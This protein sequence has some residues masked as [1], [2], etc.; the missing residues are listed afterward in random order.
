MTAQVTAEPAIH[1]Q[2]LEKAYK[3]LKVL[4]GVDFEVAASRTRWSGGSV[5]ARGR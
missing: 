4:R 5:R 1:T 2:G 3:E